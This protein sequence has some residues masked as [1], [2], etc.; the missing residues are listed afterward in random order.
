MLHLV[1][2][3]KGLNSRRAHTLQKAGT[4]HR[5]TPGVFCDTSDL[6]DLPEF[7]NK[8][9]LRILDYI[10]A[11]SKLIDSSAYFKG[12][13]LLTDDDKTA[14]DVYC[15][16]VAGHKAR[17]IDLPHLRIVFRAVD[18]ANTLEQYCSPFSDGK[19]NDLGL[20][21]L[22]VASNEAIFLH[23][24]GKRRYHPDRF[25][26]PEDLAE[27]RLHLEQKHDKNLETVLRN[28][29]NTIGGLDFELKGA[30]QYLNTPIN[31]QKKVRNQYEFSVGW[32]RRHIANIT[33]DG[34]AWKFNYATG[35]MLPLASEQHAPGIFPAFIK[36]LAPEGVLLGAI[37]STMGDA[38]SHAKIL[39]GSERYLTNLTILQD[40]ARIRTVPLD[41]LDGRINDFQDKKGAFT[42]SIVGVP[43]IDDTF[44]DAIKSLIANKIMPRMSGFQTKIPMNLDSQGVLTP[45]AEVAFTHILKLPGVDRDPLY[46]RGALEWVSMTLARGSGVKTCDF[47]VATLN[48][49]SVA[50][51]AER[52]D[53][54]VSSDDRRAIFA[55][56]FCSVLGF[57][58]AA[59]SMVTSETACEA[60]QIASSSFEEDSVELYKQLCAS[61]FLENEDLHLKNL[62]VIKEASPMLDEF[63]SA[64]LAPA[65][66]IMNIKVL[67]DPLGTSDEFGTVVLPIND[68]NSDIEIEDLVSIATSSLEISE[69]D[70]RSIALQVAKGIADSAK[71]VINNLPDPILNNA[72][73]L[74]L[75]KLACERAVAR[76]HHMFPEIDPNIEDHSKAKIKAK[77]LRIGA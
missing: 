74:E 39:A 29:A 27:L 23:D 50:Y 41:V 66:D 77:G 12:P 15:L 14:K 42:G 9:A 46:V 7:M 71:E 59:K 51:I 70:A 17:S 75:S 37:D 68:K 72:K 40:P 33:F 62:C 35:W 4:L 13:V 16:Y 38:P 11:N 47:S 26:P 55:E 57:I 1:N 54:P 30:L 64:R 48:D 67:N 65:F 31:S 5:I 6:E 36:N 21:S 52:F 19:E 61:V 2:V 20:I 53:I 49:G 60:L 18:P 43:K 10:S 28:V 3:T 34:V 76:C 63:T 8:N 22:K 58:P 69:V 45:A 56:D 73:C 24:F 25:L 32:Y 44:N